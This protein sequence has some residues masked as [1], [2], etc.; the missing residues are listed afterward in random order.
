MPYIVGLVWPNEVVDKIV[1]KHQVRP[2][3]VEEVLFDHR[4]I[5]VFRRGRGGTFYA[6]G[7][8]AAGRKLF[9][10]LV[11]AKGPGMYRV[12]TAREYDR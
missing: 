9:I 1:A 5:P 3:E 4:S 2:E 6:T 12:V 7:R 10:V 11:K 8:T